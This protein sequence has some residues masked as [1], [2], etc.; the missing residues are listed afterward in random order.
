MKNKNEVF[1]CY[2]DFHRSFQT[3]YGAVM[4]VLRC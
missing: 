2:K 4:K 3:Q 1:D